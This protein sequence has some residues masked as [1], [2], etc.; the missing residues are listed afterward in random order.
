[1]RDY[2]QF[3][4]NGQWQ[5]AEQRDVIDVINPAT[6]VVAGQVAA[7][8]SED[9]DAAVKAARKAFKSFSQTDKQTRMDLLSRICE[10]YKE[11]STDIAAAITE[12]MGAP[13]WLA[14]DHQS[15]SGYGH[16]K[17]ALNILRDFE[18]VQKTDGSETRF[19]PIG[20]CGL[21]TPWNWPMNQIGCK[22]APA[23]ATGNTV[24]WK[25]SEVAPFSAQILMEV[26]E[27][28]G[29]PAG[30]VNMVHGDGP[31]VGSA[32]SK[33]PDIDMVSFTGSTQA[34]IEVAKDAAATIKR[35]TQELGGKSANIIL[36]DLSAEQFSKA[37]AGGAK[38]LC[39][40]SGQN[41][42]APSRLFVPLSRQ[43]EAED[44]VK[45][46]L[47]KIHVG[48]PGSET[49]F[50]GPVVSK[51][52]WQRIQN[53]LENGVA[54]GAR[55]V[56]GGPGYPAGLNKGF[57]VKPTAFSDVENDMSIAKQEIFGPVLSI[58]T[59]E[60]DQ[61]AI[62][63]ANDNPYGLSGYVSGNDEGR[64]NNI[65]KGLRAGVIHVNGATMQGT[66]P[67]G[68]YKQSG[69]GRE[70]GVAGFYEYLETKAVL[71]KDC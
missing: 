64:V 69:N 5:S 68:G 26:L 15:K 4:I 20:V 32:I 23:L 28:A 71:K 38:A 48:D 17:S 6:E 55:I 29:V 50:T 33:H 18:F 67:F 40:N 13:K 30:V 59:Y 43:Q 44:I 63:M 45:K 65:V 24:V 53:H 16:F 34:G 21:I 66:E 27:E 49:T 54:E 46:T 9:V 47:E 61:Q 1:M 2:R 62:A 70:R 56:T 22:L 41:C 19:E 3:Y 52:Q 51:T 14:A 11:R 60:D 42:N 7:G 58:L 57:Y 8:Q 31:T 10:V 25:P 12:E 36:D 37:V 39:V 35:V